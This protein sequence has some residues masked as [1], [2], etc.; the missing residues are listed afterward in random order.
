MNPQKRS[1]QLQVLYEDQSLV[2]VVKPHGMLSTSFPGSRG[3]SAQD[4]LINRFRSRGKR[5]IYAV[6]RLD[7]DTSGVM[8]FALSE[9]LGKMIMDNW[10]NLVQE[11][12]YR[13]VCL[14]EPGASLLPDTQTLKDEIA[15]NRFGIGFVPPRQPQKKENTVT[16]IT[17]IRVITRGVYADLVECNL[18]TG[19]KNQIRIQ[20]AHRGHPIVGDPNYGN[21]KGSSQRLALHA[22][23][24]AVTHPI[25]RESLRFEN[26]EPKDFGN[27]LGNRYRPNLSRGKRGF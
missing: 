13:C 26:P 16:A 24:L 6:H 17:K 22:C 19:R 2:V 14:R 10:T 20:L 3:K 25:T 21:G 9:K 15:Y 23:V 27:L 12:T 8:M 18:V 7:R 5:K 4:I 1:H 11:R